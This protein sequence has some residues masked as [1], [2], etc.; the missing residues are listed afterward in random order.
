MEANAQAAAEK[1][2]V[3]GSYV[4][5]GQEIT[6]TLGFRP[7]FVIISGM[8]AYAGQD[9]TSNHCVWSGETL[10]I[11][12]ILVLTDTGFTVRQEIGIYPQLSDPNKPYD[13]I[14][15]R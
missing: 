5:T 8:A 14:A 11:G 2:Y 1:P 3:V 9:G 7:S 6:I 13:Y 10:N 15:F 12:R 4:G